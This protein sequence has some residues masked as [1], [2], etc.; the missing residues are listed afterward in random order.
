LALVTIHGGEPS[1]DDTR[2][3]GRRI[4]ASAEVFSGG[5]ICD[6]RGSDAIQTIAANTPIVTSDAMP[7]AMSRILTGGILPKMLL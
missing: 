6:L 5:G 3:T 1:G 7:A 4:L 2:C